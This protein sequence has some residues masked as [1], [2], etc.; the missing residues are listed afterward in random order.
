[1]SCIVIVAAVT[2]V[3]TTLTARLI[4]Q[5]EQM[6]RLISQKVQNSSVR[7]QPFPVRWLD[8]L[9]YTTTYLIW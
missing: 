6:A 7:R 4:S 8:Y 3:G 5:K 9:W 1:M 2:V